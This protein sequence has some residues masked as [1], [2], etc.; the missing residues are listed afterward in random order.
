MTD[1]TVP[2]QPHNKPVPPGQPASPPPNSPP[3]RGNQ[4]SHWYSFPD[5]RPVVPA[6]Q[7]RERQIPVSHARDRLRRR[8][9]RRNAGAPDDWAWV[10]IAAALLGLTAVMS[11]T[12]FFLL[13][14]TRGDGDTL[15]T[16]EPAVEPTS[17]IYGAG[18]ILENEGEAS[19]GGLLG[20]GESMIIQPWNGDSRFTI[21]LMGMDKRPGELGTSFRTDT[22]LLISL[23]PDTDQVGMLS[24]PRDLY[25]DVP[26]YGLQRV[27]TAYGL[28]EY[29]GLG[30]G[31]RLAMQTVQYNL[32]IRVHDYLLVD[33][34]SFIR[35]VDLIDGIDVEVP[36]AIYD[37][38]YPDMNYGY[39]PFYIEAGWKHLDGA[40]ALKYARS[41]HS[42]DDIDRAQRQQQVIY[43]VRDKVLALDMIPKLAVQAPVLW[44]ELEAGIDTGL[45]M[46]QLLELAWYIK[47][48]PAG[49]FSNGVLDWQYVTP[50]T[51]Q[52]QAILVPDR[53]KIG[54]LMLDVFGVGYNQ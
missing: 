19:A 11:I 47:D 51:W 9:V 50:V 10:V 20:D 41:R 54:G 25:V 13:H 40:T 23:D 36:Y 46:E 22:M 45:S 32:G 49:N 2:T 35:I 27:N 6:P 38:N 53:S 44:S 18:G 52:G 17:V 1:D 43:A 48:I 24:I 31:P 12:V 28:G 3:I 33:F 26:G 29:E 8:K 37:P 15:A 21:L 16:S 42:S 39:D 4:G 7:A 14:A 34:A 30:G 5:Q